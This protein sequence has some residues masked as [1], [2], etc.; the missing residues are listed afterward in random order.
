MAD[1]DGINQCIQRDVTTIVV[2]IV[3]LLLLKHLSTYN[4][5]TG[6]FPPGPPAWPIFGALPYLFTIEPHLRFSEWAEKY[7]DVVH[8]KLGSK[9][10]IL[11]NSIET[12]REAFLKCGDTI[13][14]RPSL[15]ITKTIGKN[16]GLCRRVLFPI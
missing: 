6:L 4:R 8:F 10:V 9:D 5:K 2:F 11:L 1:S 15:F 16:K 13:A 3:I 12:V 7:G 14:E